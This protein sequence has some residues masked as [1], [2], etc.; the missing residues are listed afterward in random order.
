VTGTGR[1]AV[2]QNLLVG[3]GGVAVG[4]GGQVTLTEDAYLVT[5]GPG[6][7]HPQGVLRFGSGVVSGSW[8]NAGLVVSETPGPK[9]WLLGSLMNT[10]RMVVGGANFE[11]NTS[12]LTN[13]G[14]VELQAGPTDSSLSFLTDGYGFNSQTGTVVVTT[15]LC[16][17]QPPESNCLIAL[18]GSIDLASVAIADGATLVIRPSIPACRLASVWFSGTGSTL[19]V[20][21]SPGAAPV[22]IGDV[23]SNVGRLI[24]IGPTTVTGLLSVDEVEV[25]RR[26]ELTGPGMVAETVRL[27]EGVVRSAA[28]NCTVGRL[29][30]TGGA[31]LAGQPFYI[32]DAVMTS[33][34]PLEILADLVFQGSVTVS[35]TDW[36]PAVWLVASGGSVTIADGAFALVE[37]LQVVSLDESVVDLRNDG[38]VAVRVRLAANLTTVSGGGEWRV[39]AGGL[40][41]QDGRFQA[42]SVRL[43]GTAGLTGTN[44]SLFL[45]SLVADDGD[46]AYTHGEGW[47]AAAH[48]LHSVVFPVPTD[49]NFLAVPPRPNPQPGPGPTPG[50]E[51]H[52][53]PSGSGPTCHV[54]KIAWA[55]CLGGAVMGGLVALGWSRTHRRH[56]F[57]SAVP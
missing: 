4:D 22:T 26:L 14:T 35:P 9:G 30:V 54:A 48:D 32:H 24:V 49:F 52:P 10:G 23:A 15:E 44:C 16:Q 27:V 53:T 34:L 57:Y 25:H 18:E 28:E 5:E 47:F 17:H 37:S 46:V 29:E 33:S 8:L 7:I 3:P 39:E 31:Q 45:D 6:V 19:Q 21:A 42:A 2:A 1:L 20:D 40:E 51:P 12:S 43:Q 56:T 41:L 50:P 13:N 55:S 11:F 36:K 38:S